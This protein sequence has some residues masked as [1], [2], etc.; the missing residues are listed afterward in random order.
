VTAVGRT[1]ERHLK[2]GD[3]KK[4]ASIPTD[5]YTLEAG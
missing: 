2:A 5:K 1:F 3:G 4:V